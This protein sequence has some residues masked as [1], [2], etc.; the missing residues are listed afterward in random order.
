[1]HV[2]VGLIDKDTD[3]S[4]ITPESLHQN[5]PLQ[6]ADVQLFGIVTLSQVKKKRA[7]RKNRKAK[8]RCG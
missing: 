1:M 8:A 7:R 4:I 2:I 5:W 3:M 6:K